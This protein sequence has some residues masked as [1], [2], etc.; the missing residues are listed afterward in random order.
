MKKITNKKTDVHISL[1]PSLDEMD[2]GIVFDRI[3]WGVDLKDYKIPRQLVNTIID[4]SQNSNIFQN[5]DEIYYI[6]P[7]YQTRNN[8]LY[9]KIL[10]KE[11]EMIKKN[12]PSN[13]HLMSIK[14]FLKVV[15]EVWK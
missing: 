10:N 12:I 8:P 3:G 9:S 13:V 15:K 14:E 11:F 6:Y 2:I 4:D 1:Y 5:W 7:D